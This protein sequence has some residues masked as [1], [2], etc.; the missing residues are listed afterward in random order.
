MSVWW[1]WSQ[2]DKPQSHSM[3]A[4]TSPS[5]LHGV[6]A[7]GSSCLLTFQ[8]L[9]AGRVGSAWQLCMW[10]PYSQKSHLVG[11]TRQEMQDAAWMCEDGASPGK[12]EV[13]EQVVLNSMSKYR[14]FQAITLFKY[15]LFS[16]T[17]VLST[18]KI[19]QAHHLNSVRDIFRALWHFKTLENI[20]KAPL[21][22]MRIALP[23][24][25]LLHFV[26]YYRFDRERNSRVL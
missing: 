11:W 25:Y 24:Y 8:K 2:K 23:L 6:A 1:A 3:N 19:V 4:K 10:M 14:S 13:L 20:L 22:P 26:A 18:V 12:L 15:T 21:P 5:F 17:H 7:G 9:F 16:S